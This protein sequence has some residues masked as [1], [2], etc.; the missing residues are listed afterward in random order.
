MYLVGG[1]K[2]KRRKEKVVEQLKTNL[3]VTKKS[4]SK[5]EQHKR[6][7]PLVFLFQPLLPPQET[8][9]AEVFRLLLLLLLWPSQPKQFEWRR[10]GGQE[11]LFTLK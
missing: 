3:I 11:R 2:R 9:P 6:I 1:R 8:R 7:V 4:F 5:T 10:K